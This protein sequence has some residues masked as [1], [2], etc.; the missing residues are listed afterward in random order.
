MSTPTSPFCKHCGA[1]NKPQTIYCSFCGKP[2]Q[3]PEAVNYDNNSGNLLAGAMLKGRYR[4]IKSVGQGGMGTVYR[5][6]DAE[7]NGRPIAVKEMILG[8]L[9]AKSTSFGFRARYDVIS[10]WKGLNGDNPPVAFYPLGQTNVIA[11]VARDNT[12]DIY[13]NGKKV[14]RITDNTYSMGVIGLSADAPDHD[15]TVV[16]QD[17]RIW[18][19]P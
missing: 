12:F 5:A 2:L 4:I 16:Y 7:L 19:L 3:E 6:Q 17:V 1:A 11:I 8:N 10:G 18:A 9:S 14:D 15:T 13:A